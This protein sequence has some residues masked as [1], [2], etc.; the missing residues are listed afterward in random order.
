MTGL[1][2]IWPAAIGFAHVLVQRDRIINPKL[3]MVV[4]VSCG[5]G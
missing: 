5:P 1:S 4:Q 2:T 3:M